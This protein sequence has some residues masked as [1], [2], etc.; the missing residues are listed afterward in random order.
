MIRNIILPA[1]YLSIFTVVIYVEKKLTSI[2]MVAQKVSAIILRG[3]Y[4]LMRCGH[5][6]ITPKKGGE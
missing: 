2:V 3:Y 4:S 6:S 5:T 1:D